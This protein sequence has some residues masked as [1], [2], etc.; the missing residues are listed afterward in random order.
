MAFCRVVSKLSNFIILIGSLKIL[1][2][3][4][5]IKNMAPCSTKSQSNYK[6]SVTSGEGLKKGSNFG[7]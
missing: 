1:Y 5:A 6:E 4:R 7:F 2:F 3:S